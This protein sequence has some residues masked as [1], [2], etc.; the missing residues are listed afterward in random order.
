MFQ[1]QIADMDAT[2][3]SIPVSWCLDEES[4][5]WMAENNIADP[6]V[7]IVVSPVNTEEQKHRYH[8]SSEYRKVVPLQDLMTYVEFRYSG[9]NKIWG[10]ISSKDKKSDV[11][12]TYLD[13]QGGKFETN[14][15]DFDGE[16]YAQWLKDADNSSGKTLSVPL[17][18]EVPEGVFAPEP[19][20]WEKAWVNYL[21]R[22]KV[23]DQCEFRKRR[24]FA[25]GVQPFIMLVSLL[26][27]TLMLVVSCALLLRS[28]S[29]KYLL[30]PLTYSLSECTELFNES[31]FIVFSHPLDYEWV[32]EFPPPTY[33]IRKFWLLPLLPIV[34]IPLAVLAIKGLFFAFAICCAVALAGPIIILMVSIK[35]LNKRNKDD[36]KP[37]W[38]MEKDERT[39]IT[40]APDRKPISYKSIPARR[41]SIYLRFQNIK[42]KVCKPF[43]L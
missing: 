15:L 8:I 2:S 7:V 9:L 4:I 35:Y 5:K 19:A 18:V 1:L 11:R 10:F 30:H 38:Y 3:G 28:V 17:E 39:M 14:I 26:L 6:Q 25:Y 24:L 37:L 13:R 40:C 41:K 34:W 29:L 32:T 22:E 16:E 33:F 21:F 43:S 42:S 20:S 12:L 36:P 31:P 27:R 23:V